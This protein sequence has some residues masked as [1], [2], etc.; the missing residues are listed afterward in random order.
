MIELAGC[1]TSRNGVLGD[2]GTFDQRF[3][4]T[5]VGASSDWQV[6][7]SGRTHSCGVRDGALFCWG[8]NLD[9]QLAA[10][11]SNDL[12]QY[13]SPFQVASAK[14][15]LPSPRAMPIAARR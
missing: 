5:R 10:P 15:G 1:C 2:G 13:R 11:A 3:V 12:L 7:S 6:V 14:I 9:G 4:P 8:R